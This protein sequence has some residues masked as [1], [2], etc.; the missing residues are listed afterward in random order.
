MKESVKPLRRSRL[1]NIFD[2]SPG[3]SR[4]TVCRLYRMVAG[5]TT[6]VLLVGSRM[7]VLHAAP[8]T[9]WQLETIAAGVSAEARNSAL[10]IDSTGMIHV[11]YYDE[12]GSNQFVL[13]HTVKTAAGWNTEVIDQ[14]KGDPPV[15]RFD[16]A[17]RLHIAYSHIVGRE[18]IRYG[19]LDNGVWS[20]EN[21]H[22]PDIRGRNPLLEFDS[23]EQPHI[24]FNDNGGLGSAAFYATRSGSGW[25]LEQVGLAI[26]GASFN[27]GAM[28]FDLQDKPFLFGNLGNSGFRVASRGSS[29]WSISG[30]L[31]PP[32]T[33]PN[34]SGTGA[35]AAG[36]FHVAGVTFGPTDDLYYLVGKDASWSNQR[37]EHTGPIG[38]S[39]TSI[40]LGLDGWPR[41]SY[42]VDTDGSGRTRIK[43][44]FYTGSQWITEFVSSDVAVQS[45][46]SLAVDDFGAS[47]MVYWAEDGRLVHATAFVPEPT[48]WL[49]AVCGML[50]LLVF[51]KSIPGLCSL[52]VGS[53][54]NFQ[55][56]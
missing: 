52:T 39:N 35:D 16:S 15:M 25:T 40:A 53:A 8:G 49:M 47:H 24:A 26:E 2:W 27:P 32:L 46:T 38:L 23:H 21:V 54:G 10:A 36:N 28:G 51:R 6:L 30:S 14:A 11:L 37:I 4:A 48:T 29:T 13:K 56:T 50:M 55:R 22:S 34:M 44:A 43:H 18:Y 1:A 45:G 31:G 42:E 3:L 12:L 20:L 17:G 9:E 41:I 7:S 33:R 19:V 5:A